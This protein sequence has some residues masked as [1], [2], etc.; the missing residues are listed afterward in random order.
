M[1]L[2]DATTDDWLERY[3][4]AAQNRSPNDGSAD[5]TYEAAPS[6]LPRSLPQRPPLSLAGPGDG[7][8]D[9]WP[10]APVA[11]LVMVPQAGQS[12]G[13]P[14]WAQAPTGNPFAGFM[15]PKENLTARALRMKG[16]PEA[17]IAAAAA[18]PELMKQLITQ[19]FGPGS[20]AAQS[21]SPG[22]AVPPIG[23]NRMSTIAALRG[24][25][26]AG[27]Y[28]DKGTALLN[29]AAQPW[30]ETGLSH[31]GT[32]AERTAENENTIKAA[33]NQYEK[34]HPIGTHVGKFAIGAGALA[35]F[36]ATALGARAFGMAGGGAVAVRPEGGN[37]IRTAQ[38]RR[39]R[40]ARR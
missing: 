5:A 20:A 19:H 11:P 8:S 9:V 40:A 10:S 2:L 14:S 35:P 22:A 21:A 1:G 23:E 26:L 4:R 34:D 39:Y 31:A 30:L 28:V 24:I 3:R 6:W 27:A 33:T 16:V 29:A 36:G 13:L 38:C 37:D 12:A 32:F 17:D 18:A 7:A 25:P 15:A